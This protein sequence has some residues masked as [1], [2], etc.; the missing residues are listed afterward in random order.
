MSHNTKRKILTVLLSV[1]MLLQLMP[2]PA[3]A[4]IFSSAIRFSISGFEPGS[5]DKTGE[6]IWLPGYPTGY[7]LPQV[8]L[9]LYRDDTQ[10][11]DT[12]QIKVPIGDPVIVD[13]NE[14]EPWKYTWYS[15]PEFN[16]SDGS[17]IKY[18]IE[19][20]YEPL[21]FKQI[22]DTDPMT[23]T[24]VY[25][26]ATGNLNIQ[27]G[28]KVSFIGPCDVGSFSFTLYHASGEASYT[29]DST[30]DTWNG[31]PYGNY[32]IR[33]ND[34]NPNVEYELKIGYV[35]QGSIVYYISVC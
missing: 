15:L 16:I 35:Q 11:G 12:T 27:V 9:Q 24:N 23:V 3:L 20:V 6:K 8:T 19:E 25:D 33:V 29:F 26:S 5:V 17:F 1:V 14:T 30:D 32:Y 22:S 2:I 4:Q 21:Y 28:S 10:P 34:N 18:F 13:G 7:T 31:A